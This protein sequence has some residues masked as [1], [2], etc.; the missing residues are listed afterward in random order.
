M[1]PDVGDI[2]QNSF[3]TLIG[4]VAP[5]LRND[6]ALGST[7]VIALMMLF[8]AQEFERGADQRFRENTA[9]RE[10]FRE[11]AA[12]V[13]DLPLRSRLAAQAASREESL[14]ISALTAS[15]NTLRDLLIELHRFVET[16]EDPLGTELDRRIWAHLRRFAEAQALDM[17]AF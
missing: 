5:H 1:K 2:L 8:A 9:L 4:D 16:W 13:T 17:P 15:N 11:A 12:V 6:Y 7:S 14:T 10:L 3:A